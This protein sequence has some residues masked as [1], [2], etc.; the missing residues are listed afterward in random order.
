MYL[1]EFRLCAFQSVLDDDSETTGLFGV[2]CWCDVHATTV[3]G[4]DYQTD[5]GCRHGQIQM[6]PV[7]NY[8]KFGTHIPTGVFVVGNTRHNLERRN[9]RP[10]SARVAAVLAVLLHDFPDKRHQHGQRRFGRH[11]LHAVIR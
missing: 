7:G 11:D 10:R 3:T 4:A 8:R 5:H 6:S 2:Y 9:E 1:I